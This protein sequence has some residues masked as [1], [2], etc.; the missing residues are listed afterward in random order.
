MA[1]VAPYDLAGALPGSGM[2]YCFYDMVDQPWGYD[3]ANRSAWRVLYSDID[4]SS[5]ARALP[6]QAVPDW[7]P[8]PVCE[9]AFYA[10]LTLPPGGSPEVE[11]LDL[12]AEEKDRYFS[13]I[14]DDTVNRLLGYPAELQG[15]IRWEAQLA[16]NG[17]YLG[18]GP[19]DTRNPKISRLLP[20]VSEWRLLFQMDDDNEGG[21]AW[22][23]GA[24][25]RLYYSIRQDDLRARDF[26]HIWA[27]FQWQ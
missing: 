4:R 17:V 23:G 18:S 7:Y 12:N 3:P 13:L 20:G 8:L 2:L 22:F 15:D 21:A 27:S 25:G 5:L 11:T 6:P 26:D 9:V 10:E 1:E 16:S 19:V 14:I 24:G